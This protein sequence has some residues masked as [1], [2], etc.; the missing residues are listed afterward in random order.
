VR[1][2]RSRDQNPRAGVARWSQFVDG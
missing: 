1:P 2:W